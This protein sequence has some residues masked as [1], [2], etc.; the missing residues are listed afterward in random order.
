MKRV[1]VILSTVILGLTAATISFAQE[2][3]KDTFVVYTDK[4]SPLNHYIPSGWMG[5]Y[6]DLKINEESMKEP[7]SGTSCIEI[8]YSA[9][10]SQKYGWAGMYWQNPAN[11]WGSVQGGF[12]LRGM[13]KLTF[14]AKGKVGGEI[15]EKVKVGGIKGTYLD[16]TEVSFGPIELSNTWEK[17]TINLAGEDLSSISGG[18]AFVTSADLNPKG[19]TIYIDEIKFEKDDAVKPEVKSAQTMPFY[20]YSDRI[21]V[22]NHFILS[23]W[24][25]DYGD[26]IVDQS[27]SENTQSGDSCIKISYSGKATNGARWAGIYW[28]NPANNW[29]NVDGGYD[30]SKATKITFWAKGEK[31]AERI[32]ELKIGGLMG[33]YPDSDSAGIGPVIL[34]KEWKQYVIDLKGKDLSYLSGGFAWSTNIDV[35]PQGAVFYLDEIKYE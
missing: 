2:A 16:S 34:T 19:A 17:Y 5:D 18:F 1:L 29:G 33:E 8:T 10:R 26:L 7:Y 6:G 25:G 13:T 23:G 32:E 22:K 30:L 21:S 4:G 20:V 14:W 15:I 28:Q 24:M 35:N 27:W 12:D 9:A 31:G 11:N 3:A